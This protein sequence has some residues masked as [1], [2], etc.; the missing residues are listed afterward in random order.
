[1][2]SIHE[3]TR[4]NGVT[5]YQLAWRDPDTERQE[6]ATFENKREAEDWKRLLDSN[7]QSL[8][9]AEKMHANLNTGGPTVQENMRNH[10]S[11]LTGIDDYTVDRYND[12]IRLHFGPVFGSLKVAAVD[13]DDIVGWIRMMERR[14]LSARTINNHH[15]LLSA[16][17]QTA[18]RKKLRTDNPCN[19]I[20][21]PKKRSHFDDEK[22]INRE[23]YLAIYNNM[24]QHF[25]PFIAF[26]LGTGLRF[27]EATSLRASDFML[28]GDTP[29]VRISK[30][31]K[32]SSRA[33]KEAG[34]GVRFVGPT[35]TAKGER[36]VSLAQSTLDAVRPLVEA[37]RVDG[38]PVFRMKRGGDFTAQAFYNRGW[39]PARECAGFVGDD[40]KRITPH[41]LRHLHAAT[42]LAGGMPIYDLSRRLGH[43]N[44]Q[45]TVNLYSHLLP[46]AH[47]TQAAV[48][49]KALE[50]F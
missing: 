36:T 35:K 19:G 6:R 9:H 34:G 4:S 30:A 3:R 43:T 24:D 32:I 16:T 42:M 2:A 23:D 26:L 14:G 27:S 13:Q 49:N 10:V 48:A 18:V 50:G 11:M 15:G 31:H 38:G 46:D 47:W 41:T 22:F 33:L 17:M 12:A 40:A 25:Q 20:R 45:L 7:G 37:A 44:I 21:L 39:K 8:R 29:V 28:Y 1:M 5:V